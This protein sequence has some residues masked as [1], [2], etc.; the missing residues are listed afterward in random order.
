MVTA[1][2]EGVEVP[3]QTMI[4]REGGLIEFN[5]FDQSFS[6]KV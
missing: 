2:T 1:K 4:E 6:W 5:E 3:Q